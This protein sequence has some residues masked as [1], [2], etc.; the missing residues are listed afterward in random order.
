VGRILG[1]DYGK[2]RVGLAVTDTLQIIANQ[3]AVV[4]THKIWDFLEDYFMKE[5]V[6]EVVLGYPR[7][8]NNQPSDAV[9][10]IEMFIRKFKK[11]YPAMRLELIDE[12]YTS[13]LAFQAMIDGGLKKKARQNKGKIDEISATI[14][15]QSYMEQKRFQKL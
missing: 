11:V 6:D 14:I 5:Q 15:L 1:I 3:L 9:I 2:K 4:P 7:Q 12:R 8:M 13:K 10:Y